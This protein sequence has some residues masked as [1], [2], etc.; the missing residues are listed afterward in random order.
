[1][2]TKFILFLILFSKVLLAQNENDRKIYI[3]SFWKE[4][5]KEKH[6]YYRIIKDYFLDKTEYRFEDYFKSGKIQKEGNSDDKDNLSKTGLFKYYYE[7]GNQ[8]S[9]VSYEKGK[10]KGNYTNWY[11][12]GRKKLEGEYLTT[13]VE[14]EPQ[15]KIN[16]FW[17]SEGKHEVIDGNGYFDDSDEKGS[18]KGVLVNGFKNGTWEGKN[19][20]FSFSYTETYDNGKFIS[21]K[22]I[23][24][25]NKEHDYNFIMV[26]SKPKKGIKHFYKYIGENFN[27]PR[28]SESICGKMMFTFVIDKDG[29]A[30]DFTVIKSLGPNLDNEGIRVIKKYPDWASGELRGIKVKVLY[31]IPIVIKPSQ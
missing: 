31:S 3:D 29:D 18:E 10:E 4:T 19:N 8:S 22:S 7:N 24:K 2:K 12:N 25:Y 6:T 15:Y 13:E 11:E 28:G 14:T 5:T 23:D 27:I 16:Q 26:K 30:T 20:E 9:E 1:M 17:S 21:G